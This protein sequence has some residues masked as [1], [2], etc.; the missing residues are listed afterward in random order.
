MPVASKVYT[1]KLELPGYPD[2][3][4]AYVTIVTNPKAEV[5][6]GVDT[7]D[8]LGS[9]YL[10]LSR[11]ITDWNFT[12][13]AQHPLPINPETVKSVLSPFNVSLIMDNLG[14]SGLTD[15]KKTANSPPV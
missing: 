12:D 6:E 11:I 15:S 3:D 13:D 5:W 4:K 2:D 14:F 10:V 7:Q 1:K 9:L 8:N